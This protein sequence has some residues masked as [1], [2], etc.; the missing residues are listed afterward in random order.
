MSGFCA[1]FTVRIRLSQVFSSRISAALVGFSGVCF[2]RFHN[3][4]AGLG[5]LAIPAA[6]S[7]YFSLFR[8]PL[9]QA[10]RRPAVFLGTFR[11]LTRQWRAGRLLAGCLDAAFWISLR[12]GTADFPLLALPPIAADLILLGNE[13][14]ALVVA[15]GLE[16]IAAV[17]VAVHHPVIAI[18]HREICALAIPLGTLIQCGP[19]PWWPGVRVVTAVLVIVLALAIPVPIA[20][21]LPAIVGIDRVVATVARTIVIGCIVIV[22]I[23]RLIIVTEVI[24][25]IVRPQKQMI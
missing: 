14:L 22:S 6:A 4:A 15:N 13:T 11:L 7:R 8:T 1:G 18:R 3:I 10:L 12:T 2:W 21:V 19:C 23:S 20:P 9:L 24:V 16:T 17:L 25:T 5:W